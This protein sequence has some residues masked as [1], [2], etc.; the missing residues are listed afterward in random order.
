MG[1]NRRPADPNLLAPTTN[2]QMRH[3]D[4][5]RLRFEDQEK[6]PPDSQTG[7]LVASKGFRSMSRLV[8]CPIQEES[9]SVSAPFSQRQKTYDPKPTVR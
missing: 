2:L 1:A 8:I 9:K 6:L 7:Q 3:N 4:F 5:Q